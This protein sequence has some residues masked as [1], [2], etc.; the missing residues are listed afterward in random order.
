MSGKIGKR[1]VFIE[2]K[3]YFLWR[4][5]WPY[6]MQFWKIVQFF[7]QEVQNCQ[8]GSSNFRKKTRKKVSGY[9]I[10]SLDNA[11]K[12]F[13]PTSESFSLKVWKR[14]KNFSLFQALFSSKSSFGLLA[15][16]FG[17]A[18]A[19]FSTKFKNVLVQCPNLKRKLS[20]FPKLV[21]L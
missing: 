2:K 19:I 5:S 7:F 17:N 8:S 16:K 13:L 20:I 12:K 14:P 1:T 10:C 3:V 4:S 15:C 9:V 11:A 18:A 21:L 6:R